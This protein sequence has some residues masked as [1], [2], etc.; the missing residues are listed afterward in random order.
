MIAIVKAEFLKQNRTFGKKIIW[1][2]PIV[3]FLLA[4]VLTAGMKNAYS[5]SVWNWWY[6]MLLPGMLAI[7]SYL[8]ISREKKIRYYNQ[9]TLAADKKKLMFGKIVYMMLVMFLANIFLFIGATL[10]GILLSTSV[11]VSGAVTAVFVLT[12]TYLWEIP[13]FLFLSVRFG[14]IITILTSLF[15]AIGGTLIASSDSWW[16]FVSAIPMRVVTPFLHVLPNGVRA[17]ANSPLLDMGVVVPG[18]VISLCWFV[19]VTFLFLHW[20]DKKEVK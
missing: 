14:M 4:F 11:P 8:S 2:T 7:V 6:V 3:T 17:S 10:G 18:L 1:I 16:L 13:L 19:V 20:F 15:A 5:E 12:I 9:I